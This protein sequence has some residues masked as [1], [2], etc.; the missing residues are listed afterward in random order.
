MAITYNSAH[1][2]V[3]SDPNLITSLQGD[4]KQT[5]AYLDDGTNSPT[6]YYFD[7]TQ[8]AGEK[9]VTFCNINSGV[10]SG[11]TLPTFDAD[12]YCKGYEFVKL[13]EHLHILE[14]YTS[15]GTAWVKAF[16]NHPGIGTS[17]TL[18]TWSGTTHPIGYEYVVDDGAGTTENYISDGVTGW[19]FVSCCKP[20]PSIYGGFTLV[21]FDSAVHVKGSVFVIQYENG[22]TGNSY[23]SDGTEW[24]L[25]SEEITGPLEGTALPT[26]GAST[27]RSG[28]IFIKKDGSGNVLSSHISGGGSSAGTWLTL[29]E[30]SNSDLSYS[31]TQTTNT[32]ASSDGTDAVLTAASTTKAGLMTK[33]IFDEHVLN[34]AKV[35]NVAETT[36]SIGLAANI[37][38]YT[39]EDGVDTDI[40]LSL[41]LDDTN[42][43]RITS[44]S[45][46][47]STGI[48]TFTRDDAS[49]FT[50]DM[51][52]F[53]DAITLNNTLTSTSTTE[54]LTAAQGK[55]LK[56]LI[57]ALPTSD[58][59]D[60]G[61]GFKI[62]NSAGTDQFTVTENEEIR[63][64]GSGA[65]SVSFD[66]ATQ[67]VTISSTD[68]NTD[69]VY[70]H[71]TFNGDD[72]SLDTGAL[73]G[74]T[75]ISDLDINVT[76][77]T[78]GHV[79]D[80]N[81]TVSTRTLTLSDLGFTGDTDATSEGKF[82]DGTN[83]ND[84][85][86][87]TGN[88]GIGTTNPSSYNGSFNNLVI[89][90][91]GSAGLT[92]STGN[93]SRGQIAFADGTSGDQA[94]RGLL[95]YDHA[96]DYFAI[97]TEGLQERMRIASGGNVGINNTS[98]SYELDVTG[99]IQ[100]SG[101]LFNGPRQE[102]SGSN[103]I[104]ANQEYNGSAAG[105]YFSA[106]EYQ[107]IVTII[108]GG[109]SKNYQI[110]GNV[111][112]Q[113]GGN[114]Q[115]I[116]VNATLR[117]G[118]LPDLEWAIYYE[119][120]NNGTRFIKPF[121]WTKETTTAG[122]IFGI[123]VLS[124]I[125]SIYGSVTADLKINSRSPQ[126]KANVTINTVAASEQTTVDT[127]YTQRE[128]TQRSTWDEEKLGIGTTNPG[129]LLDVQATTDP[130]IRV[131]SSGTASS[132]DALVRIRI[133][134]TTAS[135][136]ITFG[137]SAS[138]ASGLIQYSHSVDA[139]RLY[140]AGTEQVRIDSTGNVGIGV[141]NPNHKLQVYESTNLG[142]TAGDTNDMFSL[143]SE[144]ANADSLNF[145][146]RRN[147]AGSNWETA[148]HRIQ[149]K[150]DATLMGYLQFGSHVN[151]GDL[152]TFGKNDTEYM[153]IDGLGR[154]G[155]GDDNPDGL[156][157]LKGVGAQIIIDDTDATDTPR[158]RLREN[159]ATSGSI[160]TDGKELIFDSG[161][162]EKMRIDTTGNVGIG[163]A[164]PSQRLHVNGNVVIEGALYDS[165]N[166]QGTSGQVLSSTGSG[167]D[168]IDASSGGVTGV[169]GGTYI[170]TTNSTG[171]TVTVNHDNTTRNDP[172]PL[173][174]TPAYSFTAIETID[175]NATGHVTQ[176][177]RKTFNVP[178]PLSP[179]WTLS[180]DT[181]TN[182][183]ISNFNT[184]DIAG[185]TGIS[186]V[187]SNTDTL[188]VNLD[189]TAVTAGAYTSA[190]ITIDAQGR[191]TAA[192]S[193]SGGGKFVDG[194]TTT[195]AVY[196]TGNV[197]IGTTT[198]GSTLEVDGTINVN[199]GS[200]TMLFT[201]STMHWGIGD[202]LAASGGAAIKSS[203]SAGVVGEIEV[204]TDSNLVATFKNDGRIA[205]VT[206]PTA[207]Q[208][209]ATKNYVDDLEV[210]ITI[211][212]S[213]ETSD[214][215]TG[216]NKVTFRMPYAMT[217][218]DVRASV[219]TA[220]V[221]STLLVNIDQNGSSIFTTNVLS[222]DS[223]ER[224][225]TT[226]ATAAN[227]TT[228]A[229]GD[230]GEIT[231]DIAQVGSTTAGAGLKVTLIGTRA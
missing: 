172:T 161:T 139:M 130:S 50:I 83:T 15:S 96:D 201:T 23:V 5:I 80:A 117:S 38:T 17:A 152:I 203:T 136:S 190:N 138:S 131:R 62:A 2:K 55:V 13:N 175:T 85:V 65:T 51:S 184:V 164:S 27:T 137:D 100:Y 92:I 105:S 229:L 195:D 53:L 124:G 171:P 205:G 99:D 200:D 140:T 220:P 153:R 109:S 182:Q 59:V 133:G 121:L 12:L 132:D 113:S 14:T 35:S 185:G 18:P 66:S 167:I 193:G 90:G 46:N 48:A 169:N 151:S 61:D 22:N 215:T 75:V 225:S 7:D 56:D 231:I 63:F 202:L 148:S 214:L 98:P 204:Y 76:T 146:T 30:E 192:A 32:I 196:T 154:V 156:L 114:T 49:T 187:T 222:I 170:T 60:M 159:G 194:T 64:A 82:V 197:G 41:Y 126:D 43:A 198:P 125:T 91:A 135:S 212:A 70:T 6:L 77:N 210:A 165:G 58:T 36:T 37:L 3:D 86:Y 68:T 191:I 87:T 166:S 4:Q 97:L 219:T 168:W 67:K 44:G 31:S 162:T 20:H 107:K 28:T 42:L 199:I 155:I 178:I 189:D 79:T 143:K 24:V 207:A 123:E 211:A 102:Y 84:A 1:L 141:T 216:Q 11:P 186:T 208:D 177:N 218:T 115:V 95:R 173:G 69:T 47:G 227:I 226:A 73:T 40:N 21:T 145:T 52:A 158:L 217:L 39:D 127:G 181:G 108:P 119:E 230:D 112:V 129:H 89:E 118:T 71:P 106:G 74:A 104:S 209:V 180:G 54:G 149:R 57:N 157:S 224:T 142:S 128:F 33:A 206:D 78:E 101:T 29:G 122:F 174:S 183:N 26:A 134:G 88:V 144:T 188:T 160:Y 179:S 228:T 93:T 103:F 25:V 34:N 16:D 9:W 8:D 111:Y 221:G 213:D 94:Y 110:V 223:T 10:S 150:V 116:E 45:L 176:V 19:V 81:G 163:S 147:V 120:S 72:F